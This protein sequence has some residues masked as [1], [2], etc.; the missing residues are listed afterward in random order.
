MQRCHGKVPRESQA[1]GWGWPREAVVF[2]T[3]ARADARNVSGSRKGRKA[4]RPPQA[5]SQ[6]EAG[7]AGPAGAQ[8]VAWSRW[9]REVAAWDGGGP[10][11]TQRDMHEC[12][13]REGQSG[14]DPDPG[15]REAL[16]QA[17]CAV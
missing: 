4:D 10:R 3:A 15:P 11:G 8:A 17:C 7:P 13:A 9:S 6:G 2:S 12:S 1:R 14:P 5:E 16:V